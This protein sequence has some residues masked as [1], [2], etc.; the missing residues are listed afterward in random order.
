MTLFDIYEAYI[1]GLYGFNSILLQSMAPKKLDT[2][3]DKKTK[4]V[5]LDLIRKDLK[6]R[7]VIL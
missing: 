4:R 2:L 7:G 3:E 1:Y 6:D 5:R